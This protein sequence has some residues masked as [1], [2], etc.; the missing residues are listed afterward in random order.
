[1]VDPSTGFVTGNWIR[2]LQQLPPPVLDVAG[3]NVVYSAGDMLYAKDDKTFTSLALDTTGTKYLSNQ[4]TG[5]PRWD[6]ISLSS[7]VSGILPLTS[8]GLGTADIVTAR[9]TLAVTGMLKN[10]NVYTASATWTKPTNLDFII[11]EVIGAGGG[12]GGGAYNSSGGSSASASG[13]GG[14]YCKK[15]ILA[16]AITGSSVTV[17]V[18]S[19]GAGG[20]GRDIPGTDGGASSFGSFC[21]ASGGKGGSVG[22]DGSGTIIAVS[23]STGTTAGGGASGGD[24][25]ITGSAS[26][27]SIAYP[28]NIQAIAGQG[29]CCAFIGI[30]GAPQ[31]VQTASNARGINAPSYGGGGGGA[32]V[33]D[34]TWGDLAGG[35]GGSG[36]VIIYE[37]YK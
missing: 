16:S 23:L 21:T 28:S 36:L 10:Y 2:Y 15:L 1:M 22:Y 37:Y 26:A 4:G 24:I 31:N 34:L 33:A 12:G 9:A 35:T 14:G 13:G 20:T 18:G 25:N 3:K 7:G 17:T 27:L 30:G 5:A 19:G 11:V 32:C 6:A 8:G 29:G